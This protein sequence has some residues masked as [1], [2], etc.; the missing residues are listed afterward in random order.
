MEGKRRRGQQRIQ[1]WWD[2]ITDSNGHEFEQIGD[3]EEWESLACHSP[4]GHKE[5]D[6]TEPL[7]N[8]IKMKRRKCSLCNFKFVFSFGDMVLE[9]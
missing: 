5:T 3:S 1:R 4:W 6:T 8:D 7:S 2:G 9:F